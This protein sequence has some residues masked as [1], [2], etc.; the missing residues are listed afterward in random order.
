MRIIKK[1]E[2]QLGPSI[3]AAMLIGTVMLV[4]HGMTCAW[5]FVGTLNTLNDAETSVPGAQSAGWV[6][7]VFKG[8]SRLC[9]CYDGGLDRNGEPQGYFFDAFDNV[10]LHPNDLEGETHDVCPGTI[11]DIPEPIDYYYKAMF[12]ALKDTSVTPGYLHSVCTSV[13]AETK[14]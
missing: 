14:F 12:T 1:Y 10:C 6:E 8:S 13:V 4:L 3:S 2:E 9:S 11:G 5:Y 7:K